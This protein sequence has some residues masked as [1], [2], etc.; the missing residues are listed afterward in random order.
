MMNWHQC[1]QKTKSSCYQYKTESDQ[2]IEE[3]PGIVGFFLKNKQRQY[4]T[5]LTKWIT[6][7][8]Y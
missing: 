1:A 2:I 7:K 8:E 6:Q 3:D 5:S 4:K